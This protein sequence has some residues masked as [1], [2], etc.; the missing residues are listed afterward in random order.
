MPV[1]FLLRMAISGGRLRL[2]ALLPNR[3]LW[4]GRV[5]FGVRL[6][7]RGALA[8]ARNSRAQGGPDMTAQ[9]K[10]IASDGPLAAQGKAL[11][12]KLLIVDF[13]SQVTQ[14]IARR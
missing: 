3:T 14:L 13:G 1:K 9:P 8:L 11:H 2:V 4:T 10:K 5:G 7:R 6:S 12:D